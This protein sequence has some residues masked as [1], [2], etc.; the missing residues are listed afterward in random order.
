[1]LAAM[2][3]FLIIDGKFQSVTTLVTFSDMAGNPY[4]ILGRTDPRYHDKTAECFKHDLPVGSWKFIGGH[5]EYIKD[6]TRQYWDETYPEL[7]D[8]PEVTDKEGHT[9]ALSKRIA[10]NAL[11]ELR[12]E[13]H[14]SINDFNQT[15]EL[16]D[17]MK[18]G[19][20]HYMHKVTL[21]GEKRSRDVHYLH[22]DLGKLSNKKIAKLKEI[23]EPNDDM[24]ETTIAPISELYRDERGSMIL[25]RNADTKTKT[26]FEGF[27]EI[28]QWNERF[29]R[30]IANDPGGTAQ[31]EKDAFSRIHTEIRGLQGI[32]ET[33]LHTTAPIGFHLGH[34]HGHKSNGAI[35]EEYLEK[36]YNGFKLKL[37]PKA[38][39]PGTAFCS[40]VKSRNA[41]A[42][43]DARPFQ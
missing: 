14:I 34:G 32:D 11:K 5:A 8:W 6:E 18:H 37:M 9:E 20:L 3:D 25:C 33:S 13:A 1:M 15:D 28:D 39:E 17:V 38:Y 16:H 40:Y 22:L 4:V 23:I 35:L 26:V 10:R 30:R 43:P 21:P 36:T 19:T 42:T 2:N 31:A 27:P 12:E 41:T 29:D 7:A 24:I